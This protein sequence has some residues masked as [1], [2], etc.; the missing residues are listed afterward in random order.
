M[1]R[2]LQ[3]AHPQLEVIT[4]VR[5]SAG[6]RDQSSPLWK[7]TDK[8]AFTADLSA[9]I[10]REEADVVVHSWKDLPLETAEGTRIAGAPQR[11]DARDLLLIRRDIVDER[12]DAIVILSSSPRREWLLQNALPSLLPWVPRELATR[13]VRGNIETRLRKLVEGDGHGLVVAKAAIDRLLGFGPPF[14]DAASIVRQYLDA[15]HWM[16][17]P[18]RDFPWAPAQ[19]AIALEIAAERPAMA[20]LLSPVIHA[21]T[22]ADVSKER[23]ILASFGGGC[24]LALGAAVVSRQFGQ[25]VSVRARRNSEPDL[26]QW[27]LETART[28]FPRADRDRVWPQPGEEPSTTRTALDA[29]PP[30]RGTGLWVSR[31]NALPDRWATSPETLIW[32][33]GPQTWKRLAQRGVWVHGCADGLGEDEAPAIDGLAG[34]TV[35]WARLTH[36]RSSAT[37]AVATYTVVTE[38]PEDLPS[39]THFFWT[40]GDLFRQA[41]ARWPSLRQAWHGSGP[42]GTRQ[43]IEA[44]LGRC[45]RTGV[46]LDRESWEAD[47][48]RQ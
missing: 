44:T 14:E 39:R 42:G 20:E 5:P 32:C 29:G 24:H 46:W 33:A 19:G 41:I 36:A 47:I 22:V 37:N 23:E 27:T 1:Q 12:P 8:G 31:A 48:C 7:L 11:A 16:V 26:Q 15:C 45:D 35:K 18:M 34:R 6:D 25:V 17:L 2:A 43:V 28:P 4:T 40:S 10:P 38:L 13:P 30:A 3:A 9:A 21:P